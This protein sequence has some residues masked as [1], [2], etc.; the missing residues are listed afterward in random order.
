VQLRGKVQRDRNQTRAKILEAVGRLLVRAG[1]RSVGVNAIAREAG[2]DKVLIYRYFGGLPELLTTFAQETG[3]W[4][5][6]PELLGEAAANPAQLNPDEQAKMMLLAFGRALRRRPDTLEILRWELLERNELT[7]ALAKYREEQSAAFFHDFDGLGEID[8]RAIASLLAAG[9]TYLA[10]RARNCEI[11]NGIDLASEDGW[12]RIDRAASFLVD[13]AFAQR[14]VAKPALASQAKG[15][16][17]GRAKKPN[18][19][20]RNQKE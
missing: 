7:D 8:V 20:T 18:R 5:D 6:L 17:A 13:A 16:F 1:F 3:F 2:V 19:G 9:Q 4:P 14:T 10:L 11:Y 15:N 12:S